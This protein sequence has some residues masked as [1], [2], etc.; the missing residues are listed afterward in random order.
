MFAVVGLWDRWKD[1]ASNIRRD[2]FQLN[3]HAEFAEGRGT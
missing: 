3:E 2:L 1:A